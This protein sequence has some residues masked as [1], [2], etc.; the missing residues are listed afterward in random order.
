MKTTEQQSNDLEVRNAFSGSRLVHKADLRNYYY[1]H[2]QEA[3]EQ[4]FRRFL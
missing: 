4:A 1:Q 3:T 2:S